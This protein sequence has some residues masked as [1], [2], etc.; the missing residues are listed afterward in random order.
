[1]AVG[2]TKAMVKAGRS[3][4]EWSQKDLAAQTGLALQTI[5]RFESG[6]GMREENI[7]LIQRTMEAA[8]I[9]WLTL[10]DGEVVGL[11]IGETEEVT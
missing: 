10:E 3:L 5:S 6:A 8:G 9:E 11:M 4:L 1:M 2:L 7:L